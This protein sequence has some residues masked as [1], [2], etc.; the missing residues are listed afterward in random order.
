MS[1]TRL[2]SLCRACVCVCVDAVH[3]QVR[4]AASVA[5]RTFFQCVGHEQQEPFLP[6]LT[7]PM[8][9]NR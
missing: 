3:M 6:T 9:L 4:Y 2:L 1:A 5:T 8:C 7:G